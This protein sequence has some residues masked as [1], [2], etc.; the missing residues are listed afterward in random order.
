VLVAGGIGAE[1]APEDVDLR[2]LDSLEDEAEQLYQAVLRAR[3]EVKAREERALREELVEQTRGQ[4]GLERAY[5]KQED[6]QRKR[7]E[8]VREERKREEVER[9]IELRGGFNF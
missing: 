1:F 5:A 2:W 9:A 8:K 7:E 3:K 6:E 4:P